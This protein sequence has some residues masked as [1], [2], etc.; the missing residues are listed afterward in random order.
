ML[1]ILIIFSS[2]VTRVSACTIFTVSEEDT[3][4]F[5][6]NE[7]YSNP[8]TFYWAIPP[9]TETYGAVYFGFDNLWPQGGIN[10]KGLAFDINALPDTPINPHPEKKALDNYEGYIALQNCATVDEVITILSEYDWGTSMGGQIHFAD[11]NGDAVVVGPG[12]DGEVAY[13][14]K[15]TGDGY[16]IS[17]NFNIASNQK[18]ERSGLCWRYDTAFELFDQSTGLSV[19]LVRD[20]LDAVHVEGGYL[21]TL[22]S[23]IYDL[24][25][26]LIF[27]YY[28]H[29][30][31]EVVTLVVDEEIGNSFEPVSLESL[32]SA[33]VVDRAA[34][35]QSEYVFFDRFRTVLELSGYLLVIFIVYFVFIRLRGNRQD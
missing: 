15:K 13:T 8:N 7:D 17:T 23:T 16:F 19:E 4:L 20:V 2:S 18:D 24:N 34:S 1:L 22:Y 28:F 32:F 21:N 5:G 26:G 9:T 33:E 11:A 6:N 25:N 31:D 14:K 27:V 30:F 35:E 3:V 12:L 29:Q 10:E